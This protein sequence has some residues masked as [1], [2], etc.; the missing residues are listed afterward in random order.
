MIYICETSCQTISVLRFW[1]LRRSYENFKLKNTSVDTKLTDNIWKFCRYQNNK[2]EMPTF[3]I[4]YFFSNRVNSLNVS[5]IREKSKICWWRV[6]SLTTPNKI[7]EDIIDESRFHKKNLNFPAVL[8]IRIPSNLLC[9]LQ[10]ILIC[11]K[12]FL[13]L[14]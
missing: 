10:L 7:G 11:R 9:R 12:H 13:N 4:M 8:C 1:E 14:N 5:N 2:N 3:P 6:N